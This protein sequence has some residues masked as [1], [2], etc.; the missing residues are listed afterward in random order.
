MEKLVY[1]A[2]CLG[3]G[4]KIFPTPRSFCFESRQVPK[5]VGSQPCSQPVQRRSYPPCERTGLLR[6]LHTLLPCSGHAQSR[7]S[8]RAWICLNRSLLLQNPCHFL[9]SQ[10]STDTNHEKSQEGIDVFLIIRKLRNLRK[11]RKLPGP[12][13]TLI[14]FRWLGTSTFPC[15]TSFKSKRF[16]WYLKATLW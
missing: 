14:K 3:A 15:K 5:P 13:Y 12:S 11:L 4:L 9:M 7:D 6:Q 2:S 10:N 1:D 8:K 16:G